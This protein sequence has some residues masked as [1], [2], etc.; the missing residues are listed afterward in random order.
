MPLIWQHNA[1]ISSTVPEWTNIW[2]AV[3]IDVY[4]IYS[5]IRMIYPVNIHSSVITAISRH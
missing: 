3:T 5:L 1:T 2:S 4:I